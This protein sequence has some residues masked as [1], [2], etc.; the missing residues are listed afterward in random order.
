MEISQHN[1]SPD[2]SDFYMKVRP[3]EI[4]QHNLNP[5]ISDSYVKVQVN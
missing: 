3:T 4:S 5:D 2:I 1:L